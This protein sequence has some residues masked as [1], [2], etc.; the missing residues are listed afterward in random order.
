MKLRKPPNPAPITPIFAA[1]VLLVVLFHWAEA[2]TSLSKVLKSVKANVAAT[3]SVPP[4]T[5]EIAMMAAAWGISGGCQIGVNS[6]S[7]I[8]Y[9]IIGP[10]KR[11][12]LNAGPWCILEPMVRVELTTY[13]LRNYGAVFV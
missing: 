7:C 1:T 6:A 5:N 3:A 4:H 8:I 9:C 11:G 12:Q 10:N 2:L 13:H